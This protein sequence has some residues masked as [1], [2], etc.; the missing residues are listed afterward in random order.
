[1]LYM[2]VAQI[3]FLTNK[4][5]SVKAT[6]FAKDDGPYF[7]VVKAYEITARD[8][9][10]YKS[11][12]DTKIIIEVR[13]GLWKFNRSYPAYLNTKEKLDC[14]LSLII[15]HETVEYREYYSI[16][17]CITCKFREIPDIA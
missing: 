14:G 2:L 3:K 17:L 4:I 6:F 11:K 15:V 10:I 7:I 16:K 13:S 12:L 5:I 8:I 1:M 9:I